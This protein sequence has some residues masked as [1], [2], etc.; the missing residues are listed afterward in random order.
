VK[1]GCFAPGGGKENDAPEWWKKQ[2]SRKKPELSKTVNAAKEEDNDL[3]NGEL[4]YAFLSVL[5][6]DDNFSN[7]DNKLDIPIANNPDNLK[8]VA[9]AVTSDF[10]DSHVLASAPAQ[11][12]GT[13]V[14]C[15]A[16]SHFTP[17]KDQL[18]NYK[19]ILSA[20]IR[21]ADGR[22]FYAQGQGD[23]KV[24]LPMGPKLKPTPIMLK[25]VYYSDAFAFT[26]I[27]VTRVTHAGFK[28]EF[29][30]AHC[31]ILSPLPNCKVFRRV[32][33]VRG[34]YRVTESFPSHSSKLTA[35][36]SEGKITLEEFHSIMN[37]HNYTD[38][39]YMIRHGMVLGIKVNL[40]SKPSQCTIC[41]HAK[42]TRHPFPKKS[43][44]ENIKAYGNK[45]V[46]DVWTSPVQLLGGAKYAILYQ[47][48]HS[49]EHR[50][51]FAKKKSEALAKYKWYE[52]WAKV[53]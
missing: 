52:S 25:N 34:L 7:L 19:S 29:E 9:L 14:D 27:S 16:S 44:K 22:V 10:K 6:A 49:N 51:Y 41:I 26:L 42:A 17:L 21:A 13:I 45:A 31:S 36:S 12:G 24:N 2:Q 28:L 47:D 18:T 4:N 50:L 37:H 46:S 33:A 35:A 40:D 53:Q 20:P 5:V 15:G 11:Y 32:Q 39:K 48:C 23:L 1:E 43:D 30:D 38:L 8:D 3:S